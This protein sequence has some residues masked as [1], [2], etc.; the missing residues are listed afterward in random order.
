MGVIIAVVIRVD[1]KHWW[2]SRSVTSTNPKR[3]GVRWEGWLTTSF[4]Q[5]WSDSPES[6]VTLARR[7]GLHTSLGIAMHGTPRSLRPALRTAP[8]FR[9][10]WIFT[11]DQ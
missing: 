11:S 10:K 2:P 6:A 7:K 1:H 4:V 8:R 9:I 3:R 5:V